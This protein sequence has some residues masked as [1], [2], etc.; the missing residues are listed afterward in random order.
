[1]SMAAFQDTALAHFYN[2][3]ATWRIDH[4]RDGWWTL[5]DIH[6]APIERY[7]TQHQA[8]RARHSGPAAQTWYSRTDWYLGYAA[9]RTL[10]RPERRFVAQLVEQANNAAPDGA[11]RPIRFIDQAPDDDRTWTA[12]Q[13][14]DGRYYVHGA[15]PYPHDADDLEFLDEPATTR[16]AALIASL[17]G[18]DNMHAPALT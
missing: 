4:G 6:G 1:M 10:T 16:L 14:P 3:P 13:R 9:G 2:P 15:G 18:C 11:R 12:I 8:E 7:Q 17:I 5:T